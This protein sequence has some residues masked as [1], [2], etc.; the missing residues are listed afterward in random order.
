MVTINWDE[1]MSQVGNDEEFLEEV[2]QDLLNEA[3]TAETDIAEGIASR[4]FD[5]ISRA[6]HR[7]KGS[8]S[9][10][11]CDN[12][13]DVSLKLQDVGHRGH[14]KEG[15][16]DATLAE[17]K[18]LFETYKKNYQELIAEVASRKK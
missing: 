5:G 7:I 16:A 3:A 11:F 15:N 1:A 2:L 18:S 8:A 10:L 13:K 12:L 14:A 17:I 9:Y 6:A 4:N